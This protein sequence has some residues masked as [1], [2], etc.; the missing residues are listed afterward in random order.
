MEDLSQP[1][2]S[3][4]EPA[5]QA[6]AAALAPVRSKRETHAGVRISAIG[7]AVIGVSVFLPWFSYLAGFPYSFGSTS[8][9]GWELLLQPLI[10]LPYG[11]RYPLFCSLILL[12]FA[13]EALVGYVLLYS[14]NAAFQPG[15]PRP[16]WW[17]IGMLAVPMLLLL[18]A[19][20]FTPFS[21][22]E[23][24]YWLNLA[25]FI[26]VYVGSLFQIRTANRVGR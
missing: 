16:R 1:A 11:G 7:V 17:Y 18:A 23:I 2:V 13:V 22:I 21:L 15:I 12:L 8:T 4:S 24:G 26:L 10:L 6:S 3:A 20:V 25:G 14:V 9:G 5:P 19:L